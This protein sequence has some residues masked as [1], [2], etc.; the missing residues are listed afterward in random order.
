MKNYRMP[1]YV[2]KKV[3]QGI[4]LTNALIAILIFS[5]GSIALVTGYLK[6][7]SVM[8]DNK[9]FST[10]NNLAESLRGI[11]KTNPA[12]LTNIN[13]FNTENSVTTDIY[14][15]AWKT[16]V[17]RD[18]PLG[19]ATITTVLPSDSNTP[20]SCSSIPPCTLKLILSWEKGIRREHTFLLQIGLSNGN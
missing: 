8:S 4:S 1:N 12:L 6:A 2:A 7:G 13:N 17:T 15:A 19:Q 5:F 10:A 9:Y 16:Q 14:L 20:A 11:V 3:Q 18:L